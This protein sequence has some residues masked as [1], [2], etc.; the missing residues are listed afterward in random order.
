M[1]RIACVMQDGPKDCGVSCLLMII[2]SYGGNISKEK[3]RE[4]SHT[5]NQGVSAYDLLEAARQVGFMGRGITGDL[6]KIDLF[7]LPCIAHVVVNEKYQHFVVIEEINHKRQTLVILDPAQ[8]RRKYS[9]RDFEKM[10]TQQY[11]YLKPIHKL[12]SYE[13]KKHLQHHLLVFLSHNRGMF[14]L[15]FLFSVFY[16]LL[17]I[18]SSF[19]FKLLLTYVIPFSSYSNLKKISVLFM[20]FVLLQLAIHLLRQKL[21]YFLEY[22][23]SNHLMMAIIDQVV[24]LPYPYYKNR[25]TGEIMNRINEMEQIKNFVVQLFGLVFLDLV[26]VLIFLIVLFHLHSH[27]TWIL[28]VVTLLS[29]VLTIIIQKPLQ[30]RFQQLQKT[31]A[32]LDS[33]FVQELQGVETIK[34][35]HMESS[36]A[37]EMQHR[38][39]HF[40]LYRSQFQNLMSIIDY[41]K[42]HLLSLGFVYL[43]WQGSRYVILG[44]LSLANLILFHEFYF[45]FLSS[46]QNIFSFILSRSSIKVMAS[47]LEE[48]F[49]IGPEQFALDYRRV[50]KELQGDL[51]I[52][53]LSY[54]YQNHQP[55]LRNVTLHIFPKDKVVFYGPSGSGKS[56]LMKLLIRYYE[57]EEGRILLDGVDLRHYTLEEIRQQ[58]A[59]VGQSATLFSGTLY[60]NIALDEDVDYEAF[61]RICHLCQVD[62]IIKDHVLGYDVVVEEGGFNLSGGERQRIILA[63]TLLKSRAIYIFDE[64]M[65]QMDEAMEGVVLK[66]IL[67][68]LKEK[69]VI[70][71]SHRENHQ[72]LFDLVLRMEGGTGSVEVLRSVT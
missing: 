18:L 12:P 30:N 61:L 33:A 71:I 5:N 16:S 65:G 36:T 59:Y 55:L 67:A 60:H 23:L 20:F 48:L 13:P 44:E 8:G 6:G 19:E 70:I 28:I 27:L 35:L 7:M 49:E 69:T 24:L 40:N 25:S 51:L 17:N 52:E 37:E 47:R 9:F 31:H 43:L 38:Y 41:L 50:R 46:V 34:G 72:D 26:R 22:R 15:V 58:I 56:T 3:L 45:Y 54:G 39:F 11:L 62:E 14:V 2:R 53:Q 1:A 21:L 10:S 68:Y 42:E 32:E 4:L 66:N 63:R 29:F 64:A 57:V